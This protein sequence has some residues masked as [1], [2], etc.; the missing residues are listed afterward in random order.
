MTLQAE[1]V[2][3]SVPLA[4]IGIGC[5]FPRSANARAYWLNIKNGVDTIGPVPASHWNPSD[6]LDPDPKSPDHTYAARGGFLDPVDFRPL[7]FGIAPTDLEATDTSQL[8]GLVAARQALID[9]GYG[10]DRPF[11]RNRVSVILGVTGTLE[12]VIPLGARLGH[13]RW[14][15]ALA[16]AGISKEKAEGIIQDISDSYVGWQENSFP[17][18]LGNVV[19]GRIANRL[20]L[21]G[22]NCVVDAACA[23]SLSAIHLAGLELAAGRC[24]MAIS[25]GVDTFNDIFMFMCFSKTP[26]LSATGDARPFDAQADGTILGEG[27]GLVVLKRLA[28]AERDGDRIYAVI[29]GLGSS[30][31]GKGNAIYAPSAAGQKKALLN[32]YQV[33]NCTP[34]TIELVEAHGTGTRVGDAVEASAL[35]E[36]YRDARSEGAWCAVG[37]VKSQIGHTKAAAGAAGLI[38]AALALHH[39]VLPPTIKVTEP[40]EN[41]RNT[42]SPLYV[43]TKKRPWM[44][45]AEH[46]RRAAV[47]AFG[48][49]GSNFHCVLEEHQ[50]TRRAVDWEDD[51]EIIA[52]SDANAP[53][54]L[55]KLE[56]FRVKKPWPE[57]AHAAAESRARF[58]LDDKARLL[59]VV[60]RE[61]SDLLKLIDAVRTRLAPNDAV[62]FWR[63]PEGAYYGSQASS[64]RLAVL[65][66]GQGSQYVGMM[67]DLACMFPCVHK[68]YADANRVFNRIS[69]NSSNERLT[70]LIYPSSAFTKE[71]RDRQ[72]RRLRDTQIAQP[73]I[74]AV[75]LAA[76]KVL[77]EFGLKPDAY[78]GHSYGELPALCAAGCFD[79]EALHTMS[80]LRGHLM[81]SYHGGDAGCMLAVHAPL[82]TIESILKAEALD[83]V[84]ANR[85]APAQ[86]VL[87]GRRPEI[88]RAIACLDR[89][90]LHHTLLPVSAAFHSPLVASARE[91]F[92]D[93]LAQIEFQPA[94]KPVFANT[95]GQRYPEQPEAIRS[96]LA[97]QLACPVDFVREINCMVEGGV[98]TFIEVGPGSTLS[99]LVNSIL[100]ERR[101]STGGADWDAFALDASHGKKSGAH[102]LAHALARLAARGHRV[103]L[104]RWQDCP[105]SKDDLSQSRGG[106]VVPICGA[107]YVQPRPKRKKPPRDNAGVVAATP[108][109][110]AAPPAISPSPSSSPTPMPESN[111]TRS[112]TNHVAVHR[113]ETL[114]PPVVTNPGGLERAL[115]VSQQSLSAF[116]KLQEQTALLHKQF[117]ENQESAQRTL[118]MLLEQQRA[119]LLG[120][121]FAP[122]SPPMQ[123]EMPS[124]RI[125]QEMPVSVSPPVEVRPYAARRP[126]T[127]PQ[128][129]VNDKPVHSLGATKAKTSAPPENTSANAAKTI[130]ID[131]V[132]EKTGYPAEMLTPEMALDADLG[133]DSIKRVEIFSTLQERLPSAPVVKPEHLGTLQ[134]LGDVI[135]FLSPEQKRA[136]VNGKPPS[137]KLEPKSTPSATPQSTA[138]VQPILFG[139][140]A[141][142][143]GYPVEMLTEGMDLNADLGIDSIKRVEIFSAL[144]E[145]LPSAPI[146]KS[147]HLGSLNSLGDIVKFLSNGAPAKSAPASKAKHEAAPAE[148][149]NGSPQRTNHSSTLVSAAVA[150][151]I[152]IERSILRAV[153][154]V[155]ESIVPDVILPS[156]GTILL[157]ANGSIIVPELRSRM[158]RDGYRIRLASWHDT[159]ESVDPSVVSGLILLAPEKDRIDELALQG[160]RWLKHVQPGL[161]R[162]VLRGGAFFT[163]ITQLDGRFGLDN[164]DPVRD[165]CQGALAGLAKTAALEWPEV[166]CK[167]IDLDPAAGLDG[168]ASLWQE[169]RLR[170]PV[171]VGIGAQS[172][173]QLELRCEEASP[174]A[175][176]SAPFTASDRVLISGGARG[177]TGAA[178]VEIAK[179]Y[180]PTLVL[181]GRTDIEN[182]EADW[183]RNCDGDISIK[184]AL[185]EHLS[186]T[187][188]AI[189]R[190]CRN[191]IARREAL[192]SIK[193]MRDAGSRVIYKCVDITDAH[194][195]KKALDAIREE[196][197]SITSFIHGAGVLADRR[198]ED[199]AEKSFANVYATKVTGFETIVNEIGDSPLKSIVMFSSS[200]ARFGRIGQAAYAAANES[201]NKLAQQQARL[202]PDCKVLSINWG[203]WAGGMVTPA[204]QK[205]FQSEGVESIPVQS[206]CDQLLRELSGD[207][208]DVE[209]TIIARPS[210]NSVDLLVPEESKPNSIQLCFEQEVSLQAHPVLRSHIIDGR[211]VVPV[212]LHLEWLAQAALHGNP[213]LMFHGVNDLRVLNGIQL[214]DSQPRN[215]KAFAG[216]PRRH[217][218]GFLVSVE[219]RGWRGTREVLHSRADV[220]LMQRLPTP[221]AVKPV[222]HLEPYP[223]PIEDIYRYYLF[224]RDDLAGIRSINGVDDTAIAGQCHAAPAPVQWLKQ[225]L[226]SAW[227]ADPLAID[228]A[229]Q[230]MILW[231]YAQHGAGCL[232]CFVGTY[233][234]Y[235]RSFPA[236]PIGIRATITQDNGTLAR[237]DIDFVDAE[238]ALIARMTNQEC[239]IDENL[240]RAFRRNTIEQRMEEGSAHR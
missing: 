43:N 3:G 177:V 25:G 193:Q 65:F 105:R 166:S 165:V 72:E 147:E 124:T 93:A 67:G 161:K 168:I 36:V 118:Q 32:A 30:S 14:R 123:L 90:Q 191:V 126:A 108:A 26:A 92:C 121:Q 74:G 114:L 95:S 137:T 135:A 199:L 54:L 12:L 111:T 34:D 213:G 56:S 189:E 198:I 38:K 159:L 145:Q 21:G 194:A 231:S 97:D 27:L 220:L 212:A 59:L 83:L 106:L 153:P 22:T 23:S 184:R 209:V 46:P 178:A 210:Q 230:M 204:L 207:Q 78:A 144:Q 79:E 226:R 181:L 84:V 216:P 29:R 152:T 82:H 174:T 24:D 17:G 155:R 86:S 192:N 66:P 162:S 96:L 136:D 117:L 20:D 138:M 141:E 39:Q 222:P 98:G 85:N 16:D 51:V 15:K 173:V 236:G 169:I 229:F 102:D 103:D 132:A 188:G 89:Q 80:R 71:E 237:A 221:E 228:C 94:H 140:V 150:R 120:G 47:S 232:P 151:E 217:H 116:Q 125:R 129:P 185:A 76:L 146:V 158:E 218:Q 48:F 41:L 35:A 164:L 227:I 44:S 225:P 2:S 206:G 200:T 197:G 208:A 143:T 133:I 18:L 190:E 163:T 68:I 139:I 215:V 224:H 104:T 195:V 55:E 50:P 109:A 10:P 99:K 112:N 172:R 234:Q 219:L 128:A 171:E 182:A 88:D 156:G 11:D 64:G 7:D 157:I 45:R 4:I 57:L 223:H 110:T 75:S 113:S 70:D 214:E 183:L 31:D 238:G 69:E 186:L 205:M 127:A 187:P 58:N 5:M 130:L 19:A 62:R 28:D 52:L 53:A 176:I 179:R 63:L 101:P 131:I 134:T 100:S 13:P 149:K 202:R 235:R 119:L 61:S 203:P 122:T 91:P 42:T 142:K 9:A 115:Q 81:A 87:S 170:N 49:G 175:R 107:N 148:S 37:S 33:A 180:Q 6:F 201:L 233:R 240:N 239:V 8:L 167:A 196:T 60:N 211:P 160:F 77:E 40:I 1:T 154:L 73:A